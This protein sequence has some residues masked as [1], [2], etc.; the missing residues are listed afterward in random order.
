MKP[1]IKPERKPKNVY[2]YKVK[3]FLDKLP[4]PDYIST[5]NSLP[6]FLNINKRTFEKYMYTL[7]IESYEMPAKQLALLAY[8][9]HCK[10]EDLLNY[11]PEQ[12]IHRKMSKDEE[13]AA[14]LGLTK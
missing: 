7:L 9:F 8:F 1:K 14:R 4:Y 3:E 12:F 2:K 11:K 10:M 5:K 13:L 6:G